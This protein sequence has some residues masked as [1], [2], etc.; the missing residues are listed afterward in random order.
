M[1]HIDFGATFFVLGCADLIGVMWHFGFILDLDVSGQ[2]NSIDI[3]V[4][5]ITINALNLHGTCTGSLVVVDKL[6]IFEYRLVNSFMVTACV[7]AVLK[8]HSSIAGELIQIL[9]KC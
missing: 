5:S 4:S 9:T 7:I 1:G 2:V 8:W 3:Q 6:P